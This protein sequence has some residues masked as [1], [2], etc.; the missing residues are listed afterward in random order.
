MVLADT[1]IFVAGPPDLVD[2]ED[3]VRDWCQSGTQKQ[4][5][6]QDAALAGAEGAMLWAVSAVDGSVLAKHQIESVPV[7]DGMPATEGRLYMATTDGKVLS[8]A[9]G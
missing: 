8:F 7:F 9:G 5:A 6:R 1:T 3:T 4:F 2:E